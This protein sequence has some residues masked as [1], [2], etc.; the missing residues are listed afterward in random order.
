MSQKSKDFLSAYLVVGE[1]ELKRTTVLKR[2]H[3]RISALG[4]LS[5]NYNEFDGASA[6]GDAIVGACNTFLLLLMC[7]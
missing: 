3:E 6:S 7:D 2:L 5:F 1:D 4:D